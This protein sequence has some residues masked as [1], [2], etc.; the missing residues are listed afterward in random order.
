MSANGVERTIRTRMP[1][2][3][4]D[5]EAYGYRS[6]R[7]GTAHVALVYGDPESWEPTGTLARIHSECLTGEAFG[8]MRC[9]CGPQLQ[10]AL[11][12][13]VDAGSGVVV[14]L[15]GQEGRGIGLLS[16]L[17]AYALQDK[18]H[19][20]VDANL[21]LGLPA[22]AREYSAA[23]LILADLGVR[24]VRLL[25]NNPEKIASLQGQGIDV[26]AREPLVVPSTPANATYLKTKR[27]RFGH[28]IP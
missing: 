22:D 10:S 27:E 11:G 1:T 2:Q 6:T 25:T 17:A 15:R 26:V 19:D 3:H 14:Y 12:A 24:K 28:L 4:G 21:A 7:D 8:S 16:K 5:F 23:A 13:I 18:G 9:D 20:T